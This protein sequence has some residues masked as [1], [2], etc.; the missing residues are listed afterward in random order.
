MTTFHLGL[1]VSVVGPRQ[2]L[3]EQPKWP[4]AL[5]ITVGTED[6]P[7]PTSDA[8]GLIRETLPWKIWSKPSVDVAVVDSSGKPT[9]TTCDTALPLDEDKD[10][11]DALKDSIEQEGERLA[12]KG[13][14][15]FRFADSSPDVSDVQ[16]VDATDD[17]RGRVSWPGLLVTATSLA[18]PTPSALLCTWYFWLDRDKVATEKN[19]TWTVMDNVSVSAT[20]GEF[21]GAKRDGCSIQ[22]DP[23]TDYPVHVHTYEKGVAT[24][25]CQALD[26][27][28][29]LDSQLDE[30][31]DFWLSVRDSRDDSLLDLGP[32]LQ[33]ALQ[34]ATV[35][36]ALSID[37]LTAAVKVTP[38][39]GS[40]LATPAQMK[41]ALG[42]WTQRAREVSQA[43]Q[44]R[45]K[46]GI[47]LAASHASEDQ[48]L[49][50]RQAYVVRVQQI[51]VDLK[52]VDIPKG[53][54]LTI[55]TTRGLPQRVEARLLPLPGIGPA[56]V[57]T[58]DGIA[59]MVGDESL[60]L[61]HVTN[62]KL[63]AVDDVAQ[64]QMFGRRSSDR[65]TLDLDPDKGGPPWYA[66]T[67]AHYTLP[68]SAGTVLKSNPRV[69]GVTTT[70]ID[71]VLYR[72]VSYFGAN[73]VC[74]NPLDATNRETMQDDTL[75]PFS[76]AKIGRVVGTKDRALLGLPLRYGD[77]YEFAAGVIDRA[78]G[79]A[80]ELTS[81]APWTLDV[82][83][84][85][86]LQPPKRDNVR[87]LR[88]VAVGDLN[89]LP[90]KDTQ[91]PQTPQGVMLRC[92]E[93]DERGNAGRE[94]TGPAPTFVFLVPSG[95]GFV[96]PS[97]GTRSPD[98]YDF[99][100]GV[101]STDEHTILRWLMPPTTMADK[102]RE[103]AAK[104]LQERLVRIY[105]KR[106]AQLV[107]P[108]PVHRPDFTRTARVPQ[109]RDDDDPAVAAIG[110]RWAYDD[111]GGSDS[112][113]LSSASGPA[114]IKVSSAVSSKANKATLSFEIGR[115]HF[116][117]IGVSALVLKDDLDRFDGT[118]LTGHLEDNHPWG[119]QYGAFKE[120][121]IWVEVASEALPAVDA[122]LLALNANDLGNVEVSYALQGLNPAQQALHRNVSQTLIASE[123][124]IWRN[125]P[126]PPE[127]G[128]S[129]SDDE[130]RRRIASGPPALLMDPARRDNAAAVDLF[131][132]L[133]LIDAG[134]VLRAD[135]VRPYPIDTK[136]R[137]L[138]LVDGR[139]QHTH[140]D[141][142]RYA[143][144]FYSRYA[145]VLER[146][147]TD[148]SKTRRIA[149]SFRGDHL[150]IKPPKVLAVLPLTQALPS[151]PVPDNGAGGMPFLVILDESWFRE[152][153]I[154]ER[155]EA[156]IAHVKP[157]IPEGEAD[158][159][160]EL[161]FG[162]LPD[163][164]LKSAAP[165][166]DA[167]LFCFGP[168]GLSL[169]RGGSQA[170]S[171]A[172][173]FVVYP[174]PDTPPHYSLFV[175]FA[176]VL[177]LPTQPVSGKS[178]RSEYSEAFPLYSL[179]NSAAL[180]FG[181]TR[182]PVEPVPVEGGY[183]LE[184]ADRLAPFAGADEQVL[185]QYRYLLIV[186]HHVRDGGRGVDVF[187]PDDAL[188]LSRMGGKK[189]KAT[190]TSGTPGHPFEAAVVV[191][192]LLNGR[193]EKQDKHPL[194][195][196]Q[197]LRE[198]FLK[199]MADPEGEAPDSFPDDAP[200]MIRRV[201]PWFLI[202]S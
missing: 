105:G 79:M 27:G 108:S 119:S 5:R 23:R 53:P 146:P 41:Y 81:G 132:K 6:E 182:T 65:A 59:L 152:Y 171:N 38:S 178:P 83:R 161:R 154:G 122:D 36:G 144:G 61:R 164:H 104:Q 34:P 125:L 123:R 102:D 98:E 140:A 153:G 106:D 173:A 87:Y 190:W 2:K 188:W 10:F 19:G 196:Q 183:T 72:E 130:K 90:G 149:V 145:A 129:G 80:A 46:D 117:R 55:D 57:S 157:E 91:W 113:V 159:P 148:L 128:F 179:P 76:L 45:W 194:A 199:L 195:G 11:L 17:R 20:P 48:A 141:Y 1:T 71:K 82:G 110:I 191:E 92:M 201:S 47:L 69:L 177:D 30:M 51:L 73:M 42:V 97:G 197:T 134:F 121:V 32:Q 8:V 115:G 86:G 66:L 22:Q 3:L 28:T 75:E 49:V 116:V 52:P 187:M 174:P 163:H 94:K 50:A 43:D 143:V 176:R 15:K 85:A 95:G 170:F 142:L 64:I 166:V 54:R 118:V 189:V 21:R 12:G 168:F 139:D 120:T 165:K 133:S 169:D 77:Y 151:S 60:R 63:N 9:I 131:D 147:R 112:K 7:G 58:G 84:I 40:P 126:L 138:L 167:P 127:K 107:H 192:I 88:Q 137:A 56:R 24:G 99:T 185:G 109:A 96:A 124:W 70:Y 156:S 200:G 26:V 29:V 172:T 31:D 184:G 25:Y 68:G 193:F 103:D 93:E 101:P 158:I 114:T 14:L 175:E 186:G 111:T 33:Q 150:R 160:T 62:R 18:P 155:L 13:R 67:S 181:D 100:V 198:L 74:R 135:H 35:L 39:G 78:G 4:M 180:A 89:I 162:P 136:E 202:K 37:E 16:P 44:D